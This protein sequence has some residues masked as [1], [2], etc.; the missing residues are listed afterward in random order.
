MVR[1]L[2]SVVE[3]DTNALGATYTGGA[4]LLEPLEHALSAASL[5]VADPRIATHADVAYHHSSWAKRL[6]IPA[7]RPAWT[8]T[9]VKR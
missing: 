9:A 4:A 8:L 5:F 3:R 1:A 6:G 7:R 2:V